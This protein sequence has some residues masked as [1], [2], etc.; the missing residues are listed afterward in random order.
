MSYKYMTL[1]V[2]ID[3]DIEG[4]AQKIVDVLLHESDMIH[5]PLQC[6]GSLV[7]QTHRGLR[8]LLKCMW[9]KVFGHETEVY[10]MRY[11]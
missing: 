2:D 5:W 4:S 6:L 1:C 7:L 9:V 8:I 11:T 3:Y 10:E